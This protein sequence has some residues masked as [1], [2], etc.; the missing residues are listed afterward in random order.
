MK[1]GR[2]ITLEGPEGSGKSTQVGHIRA[3]LEEKGVEVVVTREPGG[4]PTGEAIRDLLQHNASGEDIAVSTEVLLFA[5]SRA[6]HVAHKIRPAI[7]RGAWVLCDR[8]LDSSLAY[9]GVARGIGVDALLHANEMAIDGLWP[10][11][12]LLLDMPVEES[13]KRAAGRGAELDRFEQEDMSFH[14]SVREGYHS[15]AQRFRDRYVTIYASA[16]V[17]RVTK[18]ILLVLS[19]LFRHWQEEE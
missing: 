16:P 2:F 13:M 4:T 5:A 1:R 17:E 11:C 6:Q 10:D 18:E 7:E 8:F 19:P 12:T 9:Q 15:L 14:R 3:W